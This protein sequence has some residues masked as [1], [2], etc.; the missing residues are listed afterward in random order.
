MYN[1]SECSVKLRS[2]NNL[3]L[4]ISNK[5]MQKWLTCFRL[6]C[7][8][9]I[10]VTP[11]CQSST[12]VQSEISWKWP[13]ELPSHVEQT[14]KMNPPNLM[15]FHHTRALECIS[16]TALGCLTM[17]FATDI[18]SPRRVNSNN[19]SCNFPS[20]APSEVKFSAENLFWSDFD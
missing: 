18:Q 15:I 3:E 9:T 14:L 2:V 20:K 17:R 16:L 19:W 4:L 13:G 5:V 10:L 1:L 7:L 8:L 12:L 6:L 11:D